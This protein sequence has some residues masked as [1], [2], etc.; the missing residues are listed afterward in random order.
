MR[1]RDQGNLPVIYERALVHEYDLLAGKPGGGSI[2]Q[3]A[4]P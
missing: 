2:F 1:N 3:I 4:E